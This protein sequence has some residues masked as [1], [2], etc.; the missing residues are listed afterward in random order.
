MLPSLMAA[1]YCGAVNGLS[2]IDLAEVYDDFSCLKKTDGLDFIITRAWHSYGA[3]DSSSITNLKNAQTAGF[4]VN[5]TD[6]YL[7]PCTTT[8]YP[9]AKQQMTWTIGN[10]SANNAKY[11]FFEIYFLDIL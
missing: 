3:F 1:I 5:N 8:G 11:L 6:V 2:G 9:T 10:L 4:P 7:F